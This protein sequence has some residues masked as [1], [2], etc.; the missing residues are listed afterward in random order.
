MVTGTHLPERPALKVTVET[1]GDTG[2]PLVSEGVI[3]FGIRSL[4][5]SGGGA[6]C[7]VG[8]KDGSLIWR[9]DEVGKEVLEAPPGV[10]TGSTSRRRK[11]SRP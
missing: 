9:N 6:V 11:G 5:G 3:H 2:Q 4:Q 7:A 10:A 1:G 8:S